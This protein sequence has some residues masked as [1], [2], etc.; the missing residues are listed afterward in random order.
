MFGPVTSGSIYGLSACVSC[1]VMTAELL[2]RLHQEEMEPLSMGALR[3]SVPVLSKRD[4]PPEVFQQC[5]CSAAV[6]LVLLSILMVFFLLV[7]ALT[8]SL[9]KT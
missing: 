7:F 3:V 2:R 8:G 5:V 6:S 4:K 1:D 9:L